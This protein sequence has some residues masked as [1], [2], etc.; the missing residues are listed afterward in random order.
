MLVKIH[1]FKLHGYSLTLQNVYCY[2][3]L[4]TCT[5]IYNVQLTSLYMYTVHCHPH[6]YTCILQVFFLGTALILDVCI[7]LALSFMRSDLGYILH[8]HVHVQS[9]TLLSTFLPHLLATKTHQ[10]SS[11][12]ASTLAWK[13]FSASSAA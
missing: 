6:A 7:F 11:S 2:V 10:A 1:H 12:L 4:R 13:S 9:L 8:V 3:C 5:C